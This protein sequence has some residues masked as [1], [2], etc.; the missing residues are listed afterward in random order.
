MYVRNLQLTEISDLRRLIIRPEFFVLSDITFEFPMVLTITYTALSE[1][2]IVLGRFHDRLESMDWS[3][4]DEI[5]RFLRERFAKRGDFKLIIKAGNL[6]VLDSYRR[7][8][9]E[10]FPLLASRGCI[11]FEVCCIWKNLAD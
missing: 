11:H 7:H 5:D 3:R 8:V 10:G 1:F 4:W 6:H 2:V 9:Q